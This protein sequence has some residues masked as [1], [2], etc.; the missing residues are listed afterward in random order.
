MKVSSI[1]ADAA[2]PPGVAAVIGIFT[3]YVGLW[4]AVLGSLALA[5]WAEQ[6]LAV[7]W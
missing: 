1:A 4:I 3:V 2:L 7:N 6:W 5:V